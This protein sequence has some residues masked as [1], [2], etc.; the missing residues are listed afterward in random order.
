MPVNKSYLFIYLFFIT[1]AD[2]FEEEGVWLTVVFVYF[3]LFH[4]MR[5]LRAAV[6]LTVKVIALQ[7]QEPVATYCSSEK[8][9][10]WFRA[11]LFIEQPPSM[12]ED[13]GEKRTFLI[14]ELSDKEGQL[15]FVF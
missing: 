12:M 14:E 3:N 7:K 5:H 9:K 2:I 6:V 4:L 8:W 15:I 1:A 11:H 13:I 10:H